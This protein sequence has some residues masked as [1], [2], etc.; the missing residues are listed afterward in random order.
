M[1]H[2][3]YYLLVKSA[4][5]YLL[6]LVGSTTFFLLKS[7]TVDLLHLGDIT[8][9]QGMSRRVGVGVAVVVICLDVTHFVTG[10]RILM[11]QL[12]SVMCYLQTGPSGRWADSSAVCADASILQI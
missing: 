5:Q 1:L 3:Y 4:N 7:T 10:C 11:D 2:Y 8:R 9:R 12:I 6:L